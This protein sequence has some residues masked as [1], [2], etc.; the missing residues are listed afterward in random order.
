MR[1]VIRKPGKIR[2]V[3]WRVADALRAVR[4]T[5]SVVFVVVLAGCAGSPSREC[6]PATNTRT[7]VAHLLNQAQRQQRSG[8]F[9]GA[10]DTYESALETY[11]HSGSPSPADLWA[12]LDA[13]KQLQREYPKARVRLHTLLS[14]LEG[15]LVVRD[16][17]LSLNRAEV[18]VGLCEQLEE[19]ERVVVLLGRISETRE[20]TKRYL[21]F[22]VLRWLHA[23]QRYE[24]IVKHHDFLRASFA[25]GIETAR[26]ST[27]RAVFDAIALYEALLARRQIDRAREL[28]DHLIAV[29]SH[30]ETFANL[31][32]AAR[33]AGNEAEA[34]NIQQRGSNEL[35][36][37]DRQNLERLLQEDREKR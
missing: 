3:T 19:Q 21:V 5:L 18:L 7:D 2:D 22:S 29:D 1:A 33:R 6:Q 11:V 17:T 15:D 4:V 31:V 34:M 37:T 20:E 26:F 16:D 28:A 13:I 25:S 9:E 24:E 27:Q 30:A 14:R 36:E 12:I 32:R 23:K 8:N 10:L 35:P